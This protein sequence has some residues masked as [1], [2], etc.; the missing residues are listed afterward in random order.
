M[1]LSDRPE[2]REYALVKMESVANNTKIARELVQKFGLDSDLDTIRRRVAFWRKQAKIKSKKTPFKR[3]F[4]DIETSYYICR[5][6]SIGKNPWVTDDKI[7]NQKEIICISYKWEGSNE[8]HTLDWR[9]G[10]K[11]MLKK[12]IKI[13]GDADELIGHNGDNFDIKEIRARSIY[14]RLLMYPTYR[15]QDTLKKARQGFRFACNKLDYLGK[16]LQVGEKEETGGLQLWIDCVEGKGEVKKKALEKMIKYCEKD[17]V[18][19]EDVYKVLS[20]YIYHN[21]N[22]AVLS[23]GEKW[24]CPECASED[25]KMYRFYAT[26]QGTIKRNM[27]C[28]NC[29][30]QYRISNRSYLKMLEVVK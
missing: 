10:E 28:G 12:F 4:F 7:I 27:K 1:R 13:M 22:A 24:D 3:L 15:T 11:A 8:V 19:L 21:N 5:L 25:V 26:A 29:Q 17:V 9:N 23:G 2:I 14:H 16:F 18:L 30:K 6:W 20:P